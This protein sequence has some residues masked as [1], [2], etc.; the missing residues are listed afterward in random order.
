MDRI[1]GTG[2][3]RRERYRHDVLR[4]SVQPEQGQVPGHV[5]VDDPA[6]H[7][8]YL[9]VVVGQL[10]DDSAIP[11]RGKVDDRLRGI[12]N[13]MLGGKSEPTP[14]IYNPASAVG[15]AAFG[16]V[17]LDQARRVQHVSIYLAVS[18]HRFSSGQIEHDESRPGKQAFS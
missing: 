5:T 13:D 9:V 16:V 11:V 18:P 15:H 1:A 6:T 10:R 12:L 14:A 8:G 7:G 4:E 2:A 3:V 17:H